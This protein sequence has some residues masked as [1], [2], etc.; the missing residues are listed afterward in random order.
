ML[1]RAFLQITL[2]G[3][4][5]DGTIISSTFY[6]SLPAVV[7]AHLSIDPMHAC[8]LL[9]R[10]RVRIEQRQRVTHPPATS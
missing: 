9:L 7:V 2:C 3:K 6:Y 10:H 5:G 4:K 8:N 1:L